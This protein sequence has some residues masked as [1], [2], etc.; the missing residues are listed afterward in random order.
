MRFLRLDLEKQYAYLVVLDRKST[1]ADITELS[2][3][4]LLLS[5]HT[6]QNHYTAMIATG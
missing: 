5:M 4:S 1:D 2:I 6:I 3:E